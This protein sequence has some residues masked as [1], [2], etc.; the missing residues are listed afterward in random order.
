MISSRVVIVIVISAVWCDAVAETTDTLPL[1][2]ISAAAK[3][4]LA[5]LR[6]HNNLGNNPV[7]QPTNKIIQRQFIQ[8][9]Q[10]NDWLNE[11]IKEWDIQNVCYTNSTDTQIGIHLSHD[12]D[13]VHFI[14][15]NNNNNNKIR[16]T[17]HN[18]GRQ[19]QTQSA[20]NTIESTLVVGSW[21]KVFHTAAPKDACDKERET[22][23]RSELS[24]IQH[25]RRRV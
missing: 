4:A 12:N 19:Q 11:W 22:T 23:M 18:S 1:A 8:N 7:T 5:A 6:W 14:A 16:I 3:L 17:H 2:T 21:E 10:A 25:N 15:A 24:D 9:E 13:L 20:T